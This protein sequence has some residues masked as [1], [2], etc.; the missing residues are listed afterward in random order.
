M[1]RMSQIGAP[2]I[3]RGLQT[4]INKREAQFQL[5]P[6]DRLKRLIQRLPKRAPRKTDDDGQNSSD[7]TVTGPLQLA[8]PPTPTPI[9]F[10]ASQGTPGA[11]GN[12]IL[13]DGDSGDDGTPAFTEPWPTT[14][15]NLPLQSKEL[16]RFH[17]GLY[18]GRHTKIPCPAKAARV[19]AEDIKERLSL[20]LVPAQEQVSRMKKNSAIE[21]E[22]RMSGAA[23]PGETAITLTPTIWILCGSKCCMKRIQKE[24][25]KM[26]WLRIFRFGIEIH[27]GAPIFA[28]VLG[29]NSVPLEDLDLEC[30][31]NLPSLSP[32]NSRLY[33]HVDGDESSQD[34][35]CGKL[36]CSTLVR[37]GLEPVQ[38][39]SRLGGMM[40]V[41]RDGGSDRSSTFGLTTAHG[42]YQLL[43]STR[44]EWNMALQDSDTR[45]DPG[46]EAAGSEGG[47]SDLAPWDDD[48][49]DSHSCYGSNSS[50][51]SAP[52][53]NGLDSL[54]YKDPR[55]V[56]KW[57]PVTS[58]GPVNF[59]GR[60]TREM[61]SD[62]TDWWSELRTD[63]DNLLF[64]AHEAD[65]ALL[66]I[67]RALDLRNTYRQGGKG[68]NSTSAVVR[69][70]PGGWDPGSCTVQ[71][72]VDVAEPV[73]GFLLSDT[74]DIRFGER[75]FQ[76]RKIELSA[77]LC[78]LPSVTVLP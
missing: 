59:L 7:S 46:N 25:A 30:P 62:S 66:T 61:H 54:G 13:T 3:A 38:V 24:V 53:R 1:A 29:A 52:A 27:K 51:S 78:G 34:S 8:V 5:F 20:D 77:P 26:T 68:S 6:V 12:S 11:N 23:R 35:A 55:S 44:T 39:F 58:T 4:T 73:E 15:V 21:L 60:G 17:P 18:Y 16:V 19:W 14:V 64:G 42:I 45:P 36:C 41:E 40:D 72:L 37:D 9:I 50:V 31:L 69:R 75:N 49:E 71:I 22:L 67:P 28:A 10:S 2:T 43:N 57:I 32:G 33:I 65:F 74:A 47:G 63:V 56:R 48:T 76:T 70:L